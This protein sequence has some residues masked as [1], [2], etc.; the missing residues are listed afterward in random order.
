MEN[1]R[2]ESVFD[3]IL[4]SV[5]DQGVYQTRCNIVF[6]FLL[7]AAGTMAYLNIVLAMTVPDHW[8]YVPGRDLTNFTIDQWRNLTLPR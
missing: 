3:R 7:A 5:G 4:N 2:E 6:N 8:C 1:N